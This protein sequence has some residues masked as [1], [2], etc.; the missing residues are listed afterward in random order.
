MSDSRTL[1]ISPLGLNPADF[2]LLQ[3]VVGRLSREE[4][5]PCRLLAPDDPQGH[6]AVIDHDSPQGQTA[7]ARLR[8][9][10]VKLLF[11]TAASNGK[12][13]IAMQRPI[14]PEHLFSLLRRICQ[15]MLRQLDQEPAPLSPAGAHAGA[16]PVVSAPASAETSDAPPASVQPGLLA[17][18]LKAR[19]QALRLHLKWDDQELFVDGEQNVYATLAPEDKMRSLLAAAPERI[20]VA[21]L[22]EAEL[23]TRLG[24][25]IT[26]LENLLWE[27]GLACEQGLPAELEATS[28]LRL[29]AWPNFT[30]KG[31][32]P[33][34][35]RIAALLAQRAASYEEIVQQPGI[36][37]SG[38]CSF[39]NACH[40]VGLLIAADQL[41]S[42]AVERPS[43]PSQRKGLL[44]RIAQ[45]LGIASA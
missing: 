2:T 42:P 39:L 26:G 3:Q 24:S 28:A 6:L 34:H 9:G 21:E 14:Q 37:R 20:Q 10:Q 43:R 17:L 23:P 35:F 13:I 15:Q 18:L 31:F 4:E 38:V 19:Q 45:R 29:K 5:L 40:A 41:A 30:R 11:A 22:D 7:M 44:N 16:Q 25:V 32:H 36:S 1:H 33:E 8:P 27:A 12:N